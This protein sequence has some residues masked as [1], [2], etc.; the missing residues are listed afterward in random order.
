M[1]LDT[2]IKEAVLILQKGGIDTFESC[3]GGV[4]HACHEP[5]VRFLGN[6]F[7]GFKAYAIA[8]NNGLNVLS[9]SYEYSETNGWLEGPHW[10]MTFRHPIRK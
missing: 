2:K 7:E 8:K 3:Q 10:R 4:G 9:L 1:D 5:M 6:S